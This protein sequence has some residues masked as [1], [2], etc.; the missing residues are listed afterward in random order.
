MFQTIGWNNKKWLVRLK[1]I[2]TIVATLIIILFVA[3][4]VNAYIEANYVTASA[5]WTEA[6]I[7]NI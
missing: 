1:V 5:Q 3:T 7:A 2:S 4:A 6:F